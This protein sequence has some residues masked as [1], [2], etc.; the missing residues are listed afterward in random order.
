M[1]IATAIILFFSQSNLTLSQPVFSPTIDLDSDNSSGAIGNNFTN[2]Y[3]PAAGTAANPAQTA[4]AD[5]DVT[6]SDDQTNIV[7]ATIILT[8]RPDGNNVERLI[9]DSTA[10]GTVNG[11]NA[12]LYEATTGTITLTGIASTADYQAVIST[13]R[14]SNSNTNPNPSDRIITVQITDSDNLP[15]NIVNSIIKINSETFLVANPDFESSCQS[16]NIAVVL[17]SSGSINNT[18]AE[19]TRDSVK[20]LLDELGSLGDGV[21]NVGIVEFA[22]IGKRQFDFT[23]VTT[24]PTGSIATLFSN[25]LD[26]VYPERSAVFTSTN[27]EAGLQQA[28]NTLSAADVLIFFTD[29]NPNT[30]I[31]NNTGNPVFTGESSL[32]SL[33]E[34]IPWANLIKSRGTHIYAF[35]IDRASQSNFFDITDSLNTLQ[36]IPNPNNAPQA[37]FDFIENFPEF[38]SRLT[39]LIQ[40]I[41]NISVAPELLLVQRI[42]AIND[43]NFT[44]FVN[45]GVAGSPDDNPNWPLPLTNFLRGVINGG[46]VKPGDEIEYTVYFLSSGGAPARNVKICSVIPTNTSFIPDAFSSN[47]GIALANSNTGLFTNPTSFL[48]NSL[49]DGDRGDFYPIFSQTPS[50]CKDQNNLTI[51]LTAAN[52]T[53]GAVLVNVVSDLEGTILPHAIEAGNPTD[54]YGFIRFKVRVD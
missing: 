6:I 53:T 31:D 41:C 35:G 47:S 23:P 37:D 36:F 43:R 30:V 44:G 16:G 49:N 34:A 2:F 46:S 15:S 40:G 48:T 9:I 25:Y 39:A 28:N 27:W 29:G 24:G 50:V 7:A 4:A 26:N 32:R 45:D 42:T 13:L 19:I 11:I 22:Q 5:F 20:A 54:S 17:D 21:T 10:G 52:N 51:P 12:S 3:T 14:Y 38:P 33:N 8:N 18:E 1:A